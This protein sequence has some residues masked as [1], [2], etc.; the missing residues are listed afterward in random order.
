MPGL[1]LIQRTVA[2]LE[3]HI[4][5]HA[6]KYIQESKIIV[7]IFNIFSCGYGIHHIYCT[8]C[9]CVKPVQFHNFLR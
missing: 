8:L 9:V 7:N 5:A 6:I 4:L 3:I 1:L 2:Y